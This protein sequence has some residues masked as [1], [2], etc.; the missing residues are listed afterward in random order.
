MTQA[1]GLWREDRGYGRRAIVILDRDGVVQHMQV[2]ERGAPD[3]EEV[4]AKVREVA[5]RPQ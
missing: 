4:V 2:I 3:V 1:Y 5:E